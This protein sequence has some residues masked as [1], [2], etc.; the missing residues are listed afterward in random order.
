MWI[1]NANTHMCEQNE[2]HVLQIKIC[3]H[4]NPK[5]LTN[6]QTHI[7]WVYFL[8]IFFCSLYLMLLSAEHTE[9]FLLPLLRCGVCI[10]SGSVFCFVSRLRMQSEWLT[11][12]PSPCSPSAPLRGARRSCCRS[13]TGT[14]TSDPGSSSGQD[15]SPS[16]FCTNADHLH[17]LFG[18]L[19]AAE[20]WTWRDPFTR[21][22]LVT[23][24]LAGRSFPGRSQ[25]TWSFN[26]G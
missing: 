1:H 10:L 12:S 17:A 24:T 20:T 23:D 5:L 18:L 19:C 8:S 21:R 6:M 9:R 26:V 4:T 7:R 15:C 16:A 11:L 2:L 3:A 25:R 22:R 14:L 13:F